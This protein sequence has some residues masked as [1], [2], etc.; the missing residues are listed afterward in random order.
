MAFY[1]FFLAKPQSFSNNLLG[2]F[3]FMLNVRVIKSVFFYFN[4]DL[5][6]L[7]MEEM[8]AYT[9]NFWN[10]DYFQLR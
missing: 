3:L 9:G 10:D 7:S 8:E 5:A 1:F 2:V 6:Y 4:P